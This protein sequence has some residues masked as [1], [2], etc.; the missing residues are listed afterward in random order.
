M[1]HEPRD[2]EEPLRRRP[3]LLDLLPGALSGFATRRGKPA[4]LPGGLDDER[5]AG[6]G[7]P[8]PRVAEGRGCNGDLH[9]VSPFQTGQ[10]F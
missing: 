2:E 4:S 7:R 5:P 1:P 6:G 10:V 9:L 8:R 3:E